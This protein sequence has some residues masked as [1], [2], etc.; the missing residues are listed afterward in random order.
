MRNHILKSIMDLSIWLKDLGSYINE[1]QPYRE[2]SEAEVQHLLSKIDSNNTTL[3]STDAVTRRPFSVFNHTYGLE[4]AWG[5]VL[6]DRSRPT[7]LVLEAPHVTTDTNS[8]FIA[9]ELWRR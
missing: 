6:I 9:L 7:R 8:E 1:S 4:E 5:A 2:P 3:E